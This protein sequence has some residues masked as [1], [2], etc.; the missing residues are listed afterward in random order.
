MFQIT[1]SEPTATLRWGK[2]GYKLFL[3]LVAKTNLCDLSVPPFNVT[4]CKLEQGSSKF[5]ETDQEN[6]N[7]PLG[8]NLQSTLP[9]GWAL[10]STTKK[11]RFSDEQKKYLLEISKRGTNGQ[12]S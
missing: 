11:R 2:G 9:M 4:D 8:E 7:V 5:V 12:K 6:V 10:K 1:L 3:Q